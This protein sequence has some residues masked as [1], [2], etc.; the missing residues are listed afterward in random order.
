VGAP[1]SGGWNVPASAAGVRNASVGGRLERSKSGRYN[2]P[3]GHERPT[4]TT[5]IIPI[6]IRKTTVV[7]Q[8]RNI[9]IE[10]KKNAIGLISPSVKNGCMK[11]S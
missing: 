6:E 2:K 1:S 8:V 10:K 5:T 9:T 4:T 11:I 3:A 7:K